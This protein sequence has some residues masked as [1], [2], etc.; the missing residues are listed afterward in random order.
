MSQLL[1]TINEDLHARIKV[2]C[3]QIKTTLKDFVETEMSK[4]MDHIE[5][6]EK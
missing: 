6:N 1:V 3:A 2:H 5:L 4:I